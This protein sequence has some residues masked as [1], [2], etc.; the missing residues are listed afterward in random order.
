ML[1]SIQGYEE[2]TPEG[3]VIIDSEGQRRTLPADT[4]VLAT[5]VTPNDRLAKSVAGKVSELYLAGDCAEPGRIIDAI[6]DG[7]RIGRQI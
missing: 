4:V 3:L 1:P 6:A 2:I 7:A 5:G